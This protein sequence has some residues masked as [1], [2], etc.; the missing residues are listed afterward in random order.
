VK[1]LE[2]MIIDHPAVPG[3]Q[4]CI[5]YILRVNVIK[6]Y[7]TRGEKARRKL[8]RYT[9]E[10]AKG[11]KGGK[12]GKGGKGGKGGKSAKGGK[13]GKSGKRW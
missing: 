1:D 2:K 13:G 5:Q 4:T 9:Y 3:I 10:S 6:Y 8:G 7:R 12:S 11:G